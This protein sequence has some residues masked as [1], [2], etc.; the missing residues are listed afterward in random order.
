MCRRLCCLIQF[1]SVEVSTKQNHKSFCAGHHLYDFFIG[2]ELNPRIS[3][4]DLK[5]FCELYPGLIGWLLIDLGMLQKQ[6]QVCAPAPAEL[7]GTCDPP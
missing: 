6:R 7:A 1:Q 3:C 2:R 5:E 4:F